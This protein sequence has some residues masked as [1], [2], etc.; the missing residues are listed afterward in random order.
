ML[1]PSRHHK[2]RNMLKAGEACVANAGCR[3]T[4]TPLGSTS[5]ADTDLTAAGPS[6]AT[7][8]REVTTH[9]SCNIKYARQMLATFTSLIFQAVTRHDD[10]RMTTHS[11]PTFK[12]RDGSG[13]VGPPFAG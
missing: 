1:S 8:Q 3:K 7:A 6:S 12:M 10:L 5:R 11:Y 4:Q 9:L 13:L 2:L